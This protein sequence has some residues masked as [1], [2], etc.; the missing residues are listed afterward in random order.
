MGFYLG[1]RKIWDKPKFGPLWTFLIRILLNVIFL[2]MDQSHMYY[3]KSFKMSICISF[4]LYWLK[5]YWQLIPRLKKSKFYEKKFPKFNFYLIFK[6]FTPK[7]L[8]NHW[9]LRKNT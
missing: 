6:I 1:L 4:K 8:Q 9:L 7:Y 2:F 5:S 3:S